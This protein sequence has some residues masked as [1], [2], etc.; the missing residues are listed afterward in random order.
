[1]AVNGDTEFVPFV[2]KEIVLFSNSLHYKN[3]E[4]DYCIPSEKAGKWLTKNKGKY[5]PQ[6]SEFNKLV[7]LR[8]VSIPYIIPLIKGADIT[9]GSIE[10]SNVVGKLVAYH[11]AAVEWLCLM[12]MEPCC[13]SKLWCGEGDNQCPRPVNNKNVALSYNGELFIKVLI[14]DRSKQK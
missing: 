12:N 4:L 10:D 8:I 1:V 9:K 7:N 11:D 6:P 5:P 14:G 13:N 3:G 2:V